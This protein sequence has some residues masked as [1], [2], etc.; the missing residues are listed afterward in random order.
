MEP[1]ADQIEEIYG[2]SLSD[3]TT[4]C[5]F[6]ALGFHS[7]S[8]KLSS[9]RKRPVLVTREN[10]HSGSVVA[11]R[12]RKALSQPAAGGVYTTNRQPQRRRTRTFE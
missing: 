5:S 6:G 7:T 3:P 9:N 8:Q 12:S 4:N 1:S 11:T 10:L 2:I